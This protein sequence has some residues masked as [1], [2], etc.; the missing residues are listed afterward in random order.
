MTVGGS[1]GG[2]AGRHGRLRGALAAYASFEPDARRFLVVTLVVGAAQSL[3]W[4]DFNLYLGSL[5]L[6]NSFV[7]VV[8]AVG[9]LAAMVVAFPASAVSDRIG[10]R[11]VLLV[12]VALTVVATTGLVAIPEPVAIIVLAAILA[13]GQQTFAVVTVPY[14][15]E[16]STRDHRAELFAAQYATMTFTGV[17][18]AMLGAVV[19]AIAS[20]AWGL[21]SGDPAV[22]RVLLA[23]MVGFG[24]VGFAILLTL[25]DDRPSRRRPRTAEQ[26]A[27]DGW[28]GEPIAQRADRARPRTL[29]RVGIVVHDRALFFKLLFPGFLTALGAGQVIPFLN[30]FVETKFDLSLASL[31]LVFA[32]SALGTT[33]A[34]LLQPV[35]ARRVGK[36]GSVVL[37]QSVSIPFIVVLGWSPLL[38]TVVLALAVRNS[39]MNAGSPMITAFSQEQVRPDERATLAAAQNLLWSLG[40]VIAGLWYGVLQATLGFS[41]GYT[42]AFATII[43][44]YSVATALYW[45]WFRR[46]ESV[47][48][49]RRTAD[50]AA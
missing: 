26:R 45:L 21:Q 5:G 40:W 22:Y 1:G 41:L 47:P 32:I 6:T 4:V 11:A 18:A 9:S 30:V 17:G 25:H 37:V 13:A 43:A 20:S 8:A 33:L 44:L 10:R 38:W 35:L 42:V 15:T 34:I 7:G 29:S 31:N 16:H 46:A 28:S 12:G 19:A 48:A 23:I 24:V 50:G 39:L 3:Y 2:M 27:G 14:V 49:A 36:V